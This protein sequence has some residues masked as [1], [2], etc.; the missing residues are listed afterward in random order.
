MLAAFRT[1]DA[2]G[3]GSVPVD[4]LRALVASEEK[5]GDLT[6]LEF[7]A[8]LKLLPRLPDADGEPARVSYEAYVARAIQALL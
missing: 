1:L 6:E 8:M 7:E 4:R 3:G 2:T 5:P